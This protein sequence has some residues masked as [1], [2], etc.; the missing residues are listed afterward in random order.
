M[1]S[2]QLMESELRING[3]ISKDCQMGFSADGCTGWHFIKHHFSAKLH[4]ISGAS[5]ILFISLRGVGS[6]GKNWT[7]AIEQ[8]MKQMVH[9]GWSA[10]TWWEVDPIPCRPVAN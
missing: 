2:F 8:E 5:S 4:S 7:S 3:V 10:F 1:D 9:L 6:K